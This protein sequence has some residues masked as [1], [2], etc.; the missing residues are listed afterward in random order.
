MPH[1][2]AN[3]TN[4][5]ATYTVFVDDLE[6]YGHH[7]TSQEEQ[8]IGHRYIASIHL[9]VEGRAPETDRLED[10]VDYYAVVKAALEVA[11]DHRFATVEALAHTIAERLMGDFPTVEELEVSVAKMAPPMPVIAAVSGVVYRLSRHG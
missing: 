1:T 8:K 3:A 10:T 7:G 9:E 5:M 11:S 6:F 4:T 2:F